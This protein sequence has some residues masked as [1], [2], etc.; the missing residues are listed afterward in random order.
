MEGGLFSQRITRPSSFHAG[1]FFFEKG[2]LP[3]TYVSSQS[4]NKQL[5]GNVRQISA[6]ALLRADDH[7]QQ[8]KSRRR[9]GLT[10]QATSS[11]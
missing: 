7:P 9:C 5:V 8:R 1:G 11:S 2:V 10:R 4:M 3:E 6:T